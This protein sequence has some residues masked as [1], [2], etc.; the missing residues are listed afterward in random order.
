M[1]WV[2]P[3][4][5]LLLPAIVFSFYAAT[6]ASFVCIPDA[7]FYDSQHLPDYACGHNISKILPVDFEAQGFEDGQS[8]MH[9]FLL[10]GN[11][12]CFCSALIP[13]TPC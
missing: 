6:A 7:A 9:R 10:I 1:Q 13:D 12:N 5:L 4:A 3:M 8:G 2:Q 11:A